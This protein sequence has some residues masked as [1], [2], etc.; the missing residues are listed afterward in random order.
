MNPLGRPKSSGAVFLQKPFN[1]AKLVN[2]QRYIG[3]SSG[4]V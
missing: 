2:A 4:Q 3:R 1:A